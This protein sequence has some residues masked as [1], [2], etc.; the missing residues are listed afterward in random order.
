MYKYTVIIPIFNEEKSI[1]KQFEIII[2]ITESLKKNREFEIIAIDDCSTD[3]SLAILEK[4]NF[5]N[6]KIIK[7]IINLGYGSS[8]K[9]ACLVAKNENI[10]ICDCDL[11]YPFNR[12][13]E[14][15]ENF[16]NGYDLVIANRKNLKEKESFAKSILRSFLKFLIFLGCSEK[17]QDP[18]SGFR[19]FKKEHLLKDQNLIS[20]G[21]S[22]TATFTFVS[23]YR[24]RIIKF[25]DIDLL[26]RTGS[27]KVRFIKDSFRLLQF[28]LNI[29][30]YFNPAK[31]FLIFSILFFVIYLFLI[32]FTK[33]YLYQFI[34]LFFSL[35]SLFFSLIK[36]G[37]DR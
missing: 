23:V 29:W 14:L 10:I 30:L 34:F 21:F 32:F 1:K 4:L 9:K 5:E 19:V 12:L 16:E 7:N 13:K 35:Q 3:T 6:F 15:I 27:S 33:I 24:H 25:V 31:F 8:I 11:T 20:N 36:L 17:I 26:E 2:D 37:N 18:N 28:L 22:L